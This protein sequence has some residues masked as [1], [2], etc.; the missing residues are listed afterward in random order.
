MIIIIDA[1]GN[2]QSS[3]PESS[4]FRGSNDANRITV[5]APLAASTQFILACQIPS[6]EYL[7][8]Q[9][10]TR[11]DSDN[12]DYNIWTLGINKAMTGL[13]GKLLLQFKAVGETSVITSFECSFE[14][15][16][17]VISAEDKG[18]LPISEQILSAIAS[19]NGDI[20]DIN[21]KKQDKID[22]GIT[23]NDWQNNQ[24]VVGA[25]NNN[26]AKNTINSSNID[27][28]TNAIAK[29]TQDIAD[30]KQQIGTGENYIGQMGGET[31]PTEQQLNNFVKLHTSPSRG[32][33]GG[34]VIIFVL[35]IEDKT[36]EIY[37]YTYNGKVWNSYLIPN[38]EEAKNGSLG[39]VEGTYGIGDTNDTLVDIAG[40]KIL[41]IYVKK[42]GEYRNIVE[43]LG[44]NENSISKIINGTTQVGNALKAVQD[45]LGNVIDTTYLTKTNG[46]TK[47]EMYDY[48][49]PRTFNDPYYYTKDGFGKIP[50][51]QE[52]GFEGMS[53]IENKDTTTRVFSPTINNVGS[54][55]ELSNR[56]S[57][58]YN[59]WV[60]P[61][62]ELIS[63]R[64]IVLKFILNVFKKSK[65]GRAGAGLATVETSPIQMITGQFYNIEFDS[66]MNLIKDNEIVTI[67]ENDDIEFNLWGTWITGDIEPFKVLNLNFYSN[68]VYPIVANLNIQSAILK[69]QEGLIGE[70]PTA[71][72]ELEKTQSTGNIGFLVNSELLNNTLTEF[73]GNFKLS[74]GVADTDTVTLK[75]K[76]GEEFT[77]ITPYNFGTTTRP[78]IKDFNQAMLR[79]DATTNITSMRFEG[80]VVR[81]DNGANYIYLDIDNLTDAKTE[82]VTALENGD[83]VPKEAEIASDFKEGGT[84]ATT[85]ETHNETLTKLIKGDYIGAGDNID[86]AKSD[87]GTIIAVTGVILELT[88]AEMLEA[89][90]SGGY[91]VGQL[92][93]PKDDD[94][95]VQGHIYQFKQNNNVY[96]WLDVTPKA[97]M[98]GA[99]VI[100]IA[101]DSEADTG[102]AENLAINPKQLKTAIDGLGTVF[103][104]KGSVDTVADLPT[105][106]NNIG[107][108][109]YVKSESVGY[110]WLDDD[111]TLRWEQ[112]GATI[113][114]SNLV[115]LTSSQTITG[116]KNFKEDV[117][118]QSYF[119]GS[120]FHHANINF[121]NGRESSINMTIGSFI[122]GE[123]F[124]EADTLLFTSRSDSEN[125]FK[126]DSRGF[127]P[128]GNEFRD[129][130][131]TDRPW[132]DIYLQHAIYTPNK[133]ILVDDII[134]E[135]DLNTTLTNYCRKDTAET[136]TG[137]WKFNNAK[138]LVSGNDYRNPLTSPAVENSE[139]R[140]L[141]G[142]PALSSKYSNINTSCYMENGILYS[143]GSQ[144]VDLTSD[145][146]MTGQKSLDKALIKQL[147]INTDSP[148][149]FVQYGSGTT[150]TLDF[151]PN[152]D[153][154]TF[155]IVDPFRSSGVEFRFSHDNTQNNISPVK[156]KE[157]ALGL[158]AK[159][160]KRVYTNEI[161]DG[162]TNFTVSQLAKKSD[163]G[164]VEISL[165]GTS[166]TLSDADWQLLADNLGNYIN[167]DG[168]I[169]RSS[170]FSKDEDIMRYTNSN[171]DSAGN[172][173]RNYINIGYTSKVWTK[174]TETI[175][176]GGGTGS[177]EVV[178]SAPAS[179][180]SGTITQSQLNILRAND[181]NYILLNNEIYR[182][183]DKQTEQGYLVYTHTGQDS[184]GN[185]FIK[186]LTITISTLGWV[187]TSEQQGIKEINFT[188]YTEFRTFIVNN[189]KKI[190]SVI[191]SSLGSVSAGTVY[192]YKIAQ[193]SLSVSKDQKSITATQ[194]VGTYYPQYRNGTISLSKIDQLT[195]SGSYEGAINLTLGTSTMTARVGGV[196]ATTDGCWITGGQSSVTTG[197]IS[198][199]VYYIE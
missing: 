102:T 9:I 22:T 182:L 44:T 69:L 129:L 132:K 141:L 168:E 5:L 93:V 115:D 71:V 64:E 33:Q 193:G 113:D 140:Y 27:S 6:G 170:Y 162:T 118:F 153:V 81:G 49:L 158:A 74:E 164:G 183:A 14:V 136:I 178:I 117:N 127:F 76:T 110:V 13:S 8:E 154:K 107:D 63:G 192:T 104:I 151:L 3:V 144:V 1:F 10:M 176:G 121:Y 34:D 84:I 161:S 142:V 40:G 120:Y 196:Y 106:G 66:L 94:G 39:I 83:I 38:V 92:V 43:F 36:D 4:I 67:T 146:T 108:V 181:D 99:G 152:S 86:L 79:T 138:F 130:G 55:F 160:W 28:N 72:L 179:A 122:G 194:L 116:I 88:N 186:C 61:M 35:L 75:D 78:T 135:D 11:V 174:A 119:D 103:T 166:G 50:P 73:Y 112:L 98:T 171:K 105:T 198:A 147:T 65:G 156:D 53:V 59:I 47:K 134:L 185:Y 48:A 12:E 199:T 163:A 30:I 85:L 25:I 23:I 150:E 41:N 45:A 68:D 149:K 7:P 17:G 82:L 177:S 60:N 195:S 101:T 167:C 31:L 139:K 125:L 2:I 191:F 143:N 188:D 24:Q 21:N 189:Y 100:R 62:S 97:T 131:T 16:K 169:Y 15:Q 91:K 89:L 175:G 37:K 46:L 145:Q 42:N 172:Q 148:W 56:N 58:H 52:T 165:T 197:Q 51:T 54:N 180:T 190:N 137:A 19:L 26:T 184:T 124:I 87:A 126:L 29:N 20:A 70:L 90:T 77:I 96:D 128:L 109:W 32:P 133:D 57:F 123:A 187:M 173:V 95:Y 18:L 159:R 111:G 157:T 80:F 155:R 114:V